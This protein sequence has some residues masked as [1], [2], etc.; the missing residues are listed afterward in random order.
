[1]LGVTGLLEGRLATTH[2]AYADLLTLVGATFEKARIVKDGNVITAGGVAS[3]IDFALHLAAEIA[4]EE[5]AQA[6]QLD[7]EYDP[8]PPFASG[9]PDRAPMSVTALVALRNAKNREG[10]DSQGR[11]EKHCRARG[12]GQVGLPARAGL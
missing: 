1:V 7:I 12:P 8:A 6:I 10:R 3:G 5:A 4:G 11:P 2:W 9:H